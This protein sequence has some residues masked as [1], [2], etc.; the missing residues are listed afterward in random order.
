MIPKK[1]HYCWFGRNEKSG[2]I[3]QCIQSWR[4][5]LPDYE[6][7]EWNE[8]NFDVDVCNYTK[9][10][11]ENEKWAF[12]SDYVRLWALYHFGGVYLDTDVEVVK[13]LDGFLNNVALTGY[14]SKDSPITAVMGCEQ[15]NPI[16][17][18]LLSYYDD[19]SF[20][21]LDGTMDFTTN[22]TTI[23]NMFKTLGIEPNGKVQKVDDLVIYPQI[24]FCPNNFSRIFGIISPKSYTIHHFDQSWKGDEMKEP[25]IRR[26]CRRYFV[27]VL[28]N[29]IGTSSVAKLSQ[30]VKRVLH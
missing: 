10:A 26:R 15:G 5:K 27:G 8:D 7:I 14:E 25:N 9:E 12:V 3:K 18:Y 13:S 11:Y 2:I 22:T 24:T 23:T 20:I 19:K 4:D 21:K 17:K 30:K 16:F 6:I 28:R 29:V 1:I